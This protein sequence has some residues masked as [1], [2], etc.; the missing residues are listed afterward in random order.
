MNPPHSTPKA[1]TGD[2][3]AEQSGHRS[4]PLLARSNI[5]YQPGEN[6]QPNDLPEADQRSQRKT[7]SG[8][9]YEGEN[10]GT[11]RNR[12][13]AQAPVPP[14]YEEASRRQRTVLSQEVVVTPKRDSTSSNKSNEG[15]NARNDKTRNH[16]ETEKKKSAVWYEY[17]HV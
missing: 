16:E 2:K 3:S 4:S 11:V 9:F 17:G 1:E 8:V 13:E 12:S 7:S 10:G 14:P 5:F 15:A 6:N